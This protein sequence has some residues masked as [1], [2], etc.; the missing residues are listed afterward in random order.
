MA[1]LF[2]KILKKNAHVAWD[3]ECQETLDKWKWYLMSLQMLLPLKLGRPLILYL[4]I[5]IESLSAMLARKR[6]MDG[7]ECAI[8]YL[9]KKFCTIE[10]NYFATEKTCFAMVGMLH[11]LQ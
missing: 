10:T 2:F 11:K 8:Y 7:K 4:I 6:P 9:N 5:N 1:K 3:E